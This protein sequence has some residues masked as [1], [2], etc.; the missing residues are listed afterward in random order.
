MPHFEAMAMGKP[1]ITTAFAGNMDFCTPENS[2]LLDYQ[3][4]PVH[5]MKWIGHYTANMEWAEPD[6][7]QLKRYMRALVKDRDLGVARGK[8]AREYVLEN[9]SWEKSA[10]TLIDACCEVADG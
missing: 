8:V 7:G 9:F 4:A 6:L 1:I 2:F 3:M 5:N 10:K